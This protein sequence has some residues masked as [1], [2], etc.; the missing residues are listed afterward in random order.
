MLPMRPIQMNLEF[1]EK[2]LLPHRSPSPLV[3]PEIDNTFFARV[4]GQ[5]LF[6]IV[7]RRWEWLDLDNLV[8][9]SAQTWHRTAPGK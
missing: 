7:Y 2:S 4:R 8:V 6:P 3:D 1:L 9:T 5:E